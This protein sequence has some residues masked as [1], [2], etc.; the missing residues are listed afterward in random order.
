[1]EGDKGGMGSFIIMSAGI[2]LS[3]HSTQKHSY[4]LKCQ[5]ISNDFVMLTCIGIQ[6]V[7]VQWGRRKKLQDCELRD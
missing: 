7:P 5:H 1:M 3:L 6:T 2:L 4:S